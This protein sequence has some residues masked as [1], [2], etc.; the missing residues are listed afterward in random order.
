MGLPMKEKQAVTW[1]TRGE[2]QKAGNKQKLGWLLEVRY[3][4]ELDDLN[5][6]YEYLCPQ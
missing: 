5:R 2:Y 4:P 3:S 6:V 1:E